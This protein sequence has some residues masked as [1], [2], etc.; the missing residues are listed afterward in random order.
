MPYPTIMSKDI[1]YE[2]IEMILYALSCEHN[3]INDMDMMM[4]SAR[5]Q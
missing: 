1:K 3:Y 5:G 2:I 4:S